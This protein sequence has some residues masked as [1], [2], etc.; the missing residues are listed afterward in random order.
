[1]CVEHRERY[2]KICSQ[3]LRSGAMFA[4]KQ[5]STAVMTEC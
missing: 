3:T 4:E 5:E 2:I 1:V